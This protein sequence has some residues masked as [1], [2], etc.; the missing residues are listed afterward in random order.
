MSLNP[1]L[2]AC[3]ASVFPLKETN[4]LKVEARSGRV[5]FIDQYLYLKGVWYVVMR[6]PCVRRVE[7]VTP[8]TAPHHLSTEA[9]RPVA[10]PPGMAT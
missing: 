1:L 6:T 8:N 9:P 2:G 4:N 7:V 3:D 10:L 5:R